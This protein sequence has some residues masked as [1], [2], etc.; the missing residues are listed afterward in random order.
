MAKRMSYLW[1]SSTTSKIIEPS[2]I[3][4][5]PRII[6]VY[7]PKD[8][9]MASKKYQLSRIHIRMTVGDDETLQYDSNDASVFD[10]LNAWYMESGIGIQEIV[11]ITFDDEGTWIYR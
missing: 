7:D 8:K 1:L 3:L 10:V 2:T 9:T 5:A 11:S 4:P 6:H